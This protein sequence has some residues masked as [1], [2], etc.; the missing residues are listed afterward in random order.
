MQPRLEL[1][2]EGLV[3]ERF[4]EFVERG[5]LA[6]VEGFETLGF[7]LARISGPR[8]RAMSAQGAAL[9]N[10]DTEKKKPQRGALGGF[11]VHRPH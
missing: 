2:A 10:G 5:E 8:G 3:E 11:R 6:L 1:A 7:G 4:F 9:G